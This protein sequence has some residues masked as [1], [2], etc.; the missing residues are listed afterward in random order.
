[1]PNGGIVCSNVAGQPSKR[2]DGLLD[3]T[4]KA[5]GKHGLPMFNVNR[6]FMH[7]AAW[8]ALLDGL[9]HV[10]PT[11][12]AQARPQGQWDRRDTRRS[13]SPARE[14]RSYR[15][16]GEQG[17]RGEQ[18]RGHRRDERR[19]RSPARVPTERESAQKTIRQLL[20]AQAEALDRISKAEEE[21]R[22][23]AE[24]KLKAKEKIQCLTAE[25]LKAE[26]KI[27]RLAAETLKAEDDRRQAEEYAEQQR[28]LTVALTEALNRNL[29]PASH[30]QSRR[31]DSRMRGR[32][33]SRIPP[34]NDHFFRHSSNPDAGHLGHMRV[35]PPPAPGKGSKAP[36]KGSSAPEKGSSAPE[37]G[38][39]APGNGSSAPGNGSSAPGN[40]YK[41]R[42]RGCRGGQ[43]R[44]H[45][46]RDG[47]GGG[48]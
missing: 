29:T 31:P 6:T 7:D 48:D 14:P 45:G 11:R 17:H 21:I 41:K 15:E 12:S 30:D 16:R 39:S 37:K 42:R 13:R 47:D 9:D 23:L 10:R 18:A 35:E 46:R 24:D 44:K 3:Y 34:G 38:S 1:M 2:G 40:G 19:S 26:E 32:A 43:K 36:E 27:R 8:E 28:L 4:P 5:A 25:N 33:D 22:R 20:S